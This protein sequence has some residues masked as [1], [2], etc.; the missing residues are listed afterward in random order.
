MNKEISNNNFIITSR[1]YF[2]Q[3]RERLG[4]LPHLNINPTSYRK[5]GGWTQFQ[6]GRYRPDDSLS[7]QK[8]VAPRKT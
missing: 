2:H 4:T 1:A 7:E 6:R 5:A 8:S 3:A